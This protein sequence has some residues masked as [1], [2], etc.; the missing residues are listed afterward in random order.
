MPPVQVTASIETPLEPSA[1]FPRINKLEHY[2]PW[3]DIIQRVDAA[4]SHPDDEGPA[5][6]V[7]LG[8][9]VGPLQ[10]SKRLRM[11]RTVCHDPVEV[12]FERREH[13]GRDHS[14]WVLSANI[15]PWGP[16]SSCL[17]MELSYGGSMFGPV[18]ERLLQ[19][20]IDAGRPRLLAWLTAEEDTDQ[21]M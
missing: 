3:L 14:P 10:R 12:R 16:Q 6:T 7:D 19:R 8:T 2:P 5:W 21:R 17:A 15:D 9:R 13:D 1:L 11:V 4:E 20:E 18:L